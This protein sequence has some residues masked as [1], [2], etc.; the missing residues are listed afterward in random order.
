[1]PRNFFRRIEVVFPIEDP[2]LRRII[3]QEILPIELRDNVDAR[4][5]HADGTE[6]PPARAAGEEAFSAH[7]YFTAAAS[8][9]TASLATA[10]AVAR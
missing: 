7:K 9:R 3:L 5:L 8:V 1:M 6:A 4:E 2:E 10:A